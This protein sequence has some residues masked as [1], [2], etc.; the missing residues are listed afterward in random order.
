[1]DKKTEPDSKS[2][3]LSI[4]FKFAEGCVLCI[5]KP[6]TW[7][8]ADVVRKI[9]YLLKKAGLKTVKAGHAGTLDPLATGLLI[10][11]T[12]KATKQ[13][14]SIQQGEK[15][16]LADICFG[17]TTP[18]YDLET[19]PDGNYPFEHIT[20]EMLKSAMTSFLGEQEQ[21]PPLF[22]AKLIDGKRAYEYARKGEFPEMKPSKINISSMELVEYNPP[23]AKIKINCSKGTY[24]RSLARDLGAV[25]N[26]GA[27][28]SSLRRTA[29]GEYKVDSALTINELLCIF[30][31]GKYTG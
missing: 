17:T 13:I 2:Q 23:V 21:I 24:I 28:L 25:L 29:S 20:E 15:E 8:S 31:V 27:H 19:E 16:Y 26:S 7:T 11:C 3:F 12:G 18:S 30:D 4:T 10:V 14:E 22:S 5:D 6:Y 9:K 1:M